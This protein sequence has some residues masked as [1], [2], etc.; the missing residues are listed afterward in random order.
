M[1][2]RDSF[3][4]MLLLKGGKTLSL[5]YSLDTGLT[6][7]KMLT[8]KLSL[9]NFTALIFQKRCGSRH[10]PT[11][12]QWDPFEAHQSVQFEAPFTEAE[13]WKAVKN[14]GSL[15]TSPCVHM[16]LQ[17]SSSKRHGTFSSP[18]FLGCSMIF[19]RI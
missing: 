5:S 18:T 9:S 4:N 12:I 6:A 15:P 19:S 11:N 1:K 16:V 3:S 7:L 14:L 17:Q 2:I 13:I 8:L 10:L